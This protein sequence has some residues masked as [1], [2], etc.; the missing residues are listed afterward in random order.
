MAKIRYG[1]GVERVSGNIDG[2]VHAFNRF[3]NYIRRLA[4]PVNPNTPLQ[5]AIKQFM[6]FLTALWVQSLTA[7]QREAWN[8]Y[9]AAVAMTDRFGDTIF[10]PGMNH[11]VR[12]NIP[13]L[14]AG[15]IV[16][17]DGPTDYAL[18]VIDPSVVIT[19]TAS[20]DTLSVAFDNTLAW[21]LET[22]GALILWGG[23]PR[24]SSINFFAGPYR[25][26]GKVEGDDTTPPTSPAAI[27]SNY[28]LTAAQ[29][30]TSQMRICLADGRI[31]EPFRVSSVIAS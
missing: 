27:V 24:A 31:S 12:S 15:L 2:T 29:L 8:D 18:P 3:G 10:L 9:G 4:A 22:G 11:F 1:F 16:V 28:V 6:T 5:A 21:A 7:A 23:K 30:I 14:Q 17:F 13:R 20:D 25:F 26:A 19:A